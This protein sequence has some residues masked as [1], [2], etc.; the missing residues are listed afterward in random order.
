M[1]TD[2]LEPRAKKPQ[3]RN[4]EPMSVE[5]LQA[6]IAELEAEIARVEEDIAR[7]KKHLSAAE[8]LFKK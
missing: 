5:E 3:K 6:Y 4:L 8:S 2:D 7:K 1:D